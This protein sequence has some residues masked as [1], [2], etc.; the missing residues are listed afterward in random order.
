MYGR[1]TVGASAGASAGVGV[2]VNEGGT[3]RIWVLLRARTRFPSQVYSLFHLS[4][5]LQHA[6]QLCPH[7]LEPR[8][9]RARP[10]HVPLVAI[11]VPAL[12][13]EPL[14]VAVAL[15]DLV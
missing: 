8:L 11:I 9:Q 4:L 1:C 14:K 15:L 3:D 7:L 6:Q 12:D 2:S 10:L 13:R 5:I